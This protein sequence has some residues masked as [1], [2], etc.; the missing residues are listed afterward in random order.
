VKK[1]Q[2]PS[3]IAPDGAARRAVSSRRLAIILSFVALGFF[4]FGFGL[5]PLYNTFCHFTGLN[6]KT[7]DVTERPTGGVDVSRTVTVEFTST[8]MPGLP[9]KFRPT[10]LSLRVH[11]GEPT[12]AT[13]VATNLGGTRR[14]GQAIMSVSPEQAATHFKKIECFCYHKQALDP[15]QSRVMP[16]VF[17][18]DRDLPQDISTIT[19]SYSAFPVAEE[20][21]LRGGR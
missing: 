3:K 19:V 2:D 9:W 12:T 1:A 10:V 6:G 4:G 5:V 16:V 20:A 14:F 7:G 17:F 8:V 11:P 15:K 21:S 18:V 13:Y